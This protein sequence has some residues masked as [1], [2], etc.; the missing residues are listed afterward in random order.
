MVLLLLII[1]LRLFSIF[2]T[3]FLS[4][5]FLHTAQ[6]STVEFQEDDDLDLALYYLRTLSNLLRWAPEALW[7]VL[8]RRT[9]SDDDDRQ[10]LISFSMLTPLPV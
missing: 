1:S 4:L 6:S 8:A 9:V 5:G 3:K 2:T 10:A 7:A